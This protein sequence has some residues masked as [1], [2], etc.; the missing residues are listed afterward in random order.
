MQT[1]KFRTTEH[2][3]RFPLVGDEPKPLT[4]KNNKDDSIY[5]DGLRQVTIEHIINCTP[6]SNFYLNTN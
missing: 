5:L 3:G 4:S 2:V 1:V 6:G